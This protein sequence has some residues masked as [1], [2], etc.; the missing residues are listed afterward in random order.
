MRIISK[1]K[2]YYDGVQGLG[3]DD[4]L[5][6]VR[7]TDE[8]IVEEK[9]IEEYLN[10]ISY[11][12]FSSYKSDEYRAKQMFSIPYWEIKSNF[13]IFCGKIYTYYVASFLGN[14]DKIYAWS[15]D[16]LI[17]YF[18]LNIEYS[19]FTTHWHY[20]RWNK[21]NFANE[22]DRFE[23]SFMA[24]TNTDISD[25]CIKYNCPI[26]LCQSYR[27]NSTMKSLYKL[28]LNPNLKNMSFQRVFNPYQAYQELEMFLGN[29]L[30]ND[31]DKMI[32]L[33]DKD[34]LHKAG[35]DKWSFRKMKKS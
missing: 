18:K 12:G 22:F 27:D 31:N 30:V 28:I 16:D 1:F 25:F 17:K 19:K 29:V 33:S 10:K 26:M 9:E 20:W 5:V 23:T 21:N 2:D 3:F 8:I 4:K 32:K 6:F 35:F 34:R 14:D 7:H 13:L 11:K 24:N 15:I